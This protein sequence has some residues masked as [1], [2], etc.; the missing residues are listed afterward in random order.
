MTVT[1]SDP[2]AK[3]RVDR[4]VVR[5]QHR[6]NEFKGAQRGETVEVQGRRVT[7]MFV[8]VCHAIRVSQWIF[9][10]CNIRQSFTPVH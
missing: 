2:E 6:R 4:H 10:R 1:S 5:W 7:H 8:T 9:Q 3:Q